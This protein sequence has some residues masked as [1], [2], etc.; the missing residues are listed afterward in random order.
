MNNG[1]KEILWRQFGAGIDRVKNATMLA[2][3]HFGI[4][5]RNFGTMP[6]IAF[7]F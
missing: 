4:Q 3:H 6:I 5:T 7:S 2:H 1:L